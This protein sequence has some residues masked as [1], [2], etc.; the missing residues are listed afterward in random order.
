VNNGL[1]TV[2][3]G[4]TSTTN[5]AAI[6]G[7]LFTQPDL[8]LRIWFNDGVNGFAALDPAQPLTPAPYAVT[9]QNL[10]GGL[11]IQQ[12]TNDAPNVIGGS[13][14][15]YISNGA[16][17]A[18]IGGGGA[19]NYYGSA[20]SNSIA[21][22]FGTVGGGLDNTAGG[23]DK[24]VGGLAA[25]AATVSGGLYNTASAG[26]ATV[27]GGED[28]TA[29]GGGAT[30]NGGYANT[31]SGAYQ[32]TVSGGYF[33]TAS[34]DYATVG[35]GDANTAGGDWTTVSGGED[36]I[37]SGEGATVSGGE[38]NIASGEGATVSGG[39]YN[40]ANKEYASVPGGY[41]NIAAGICSFAA[42]SSAQATNDGAF[43]W[44]DSQGGSYSSDF[45]NQFKIRAAGGVV[46]DVSGN[47]GPNPAALYVH[48]TSASQNET[49]FVV[50]NSGAGDIIKGFNGGDSPVFELENDGTIYS[51]GIALTSDRNAK[52][53]FAA[54]NPQTVLAKVAALPVS[55]WNYKADAAGQKHL[56]P[57]AQ[58]FHAAFGLNGADD[59][60][61]SVVDESGVALAAIQGLNE[62][63]E[64]RSEKLEAENAELKQQLAE[65]KVLVGQLARQK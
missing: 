23:L 30:V 32:A 29:S 36:N 4:D 17:G 47:S 26:A 40:Q 54:V 3:L 61:I 19:A 33:N 15:N 7:S 62:K 27:G 8:R 52:E 22:D 51:K 21:A 60:H 53:N 57:M 9:A 65:L 18:T 10:N 39:Y 45:D 12:N 55:E 38:D 37:A 49:T 20:Y 59:K 25:I 48:S 43:V 11:F 50:R 41:A 56:G 34:G 42:G 16:V 2:T 31:A 58:D 13:S 44:A 5:M 24:A 63:L 28:N 6:D 14:V 35:G 46:M 64:V 1:F